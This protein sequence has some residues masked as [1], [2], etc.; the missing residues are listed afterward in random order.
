MKQP[1]QNLAKRALVWVGICAVAVS[2]QA[3]EPVTAFDCTKVKGRWTGFGWFNFVHDGRER[4]R[5]IF[6]VGCPSGPSSGSIDLQC[7]TPGSKV[8]AAA[9]FSIKNK[10]AKGRWELRNY[11]VNG[12]VSGSATFE[13]ID[14]FLRVRSKEFSQY[15]AGL[16]VKVKEGHCRASVRVDVQAPIGLQNI[17]LALRRC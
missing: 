16:K 10:R 9:K 5:C 15:G 13:N 1:I 6:N 3:A 12:T 8:D 7:K 14:V 11:N 4:A 17:D 2:A